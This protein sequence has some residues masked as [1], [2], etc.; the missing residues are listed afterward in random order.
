MTY[1]A[2]MLCMGCMPDWQWMRYLS[3]NNTDKYLPIEQFDPEKK[4]N[5]V[6][7]IDK[8]PLQNSVNKFFNLKFFYSLVVHWKTN[9]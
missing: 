2:G 9:L 5:T 8:D 4:I 6:I 3:L 1:T 7:D